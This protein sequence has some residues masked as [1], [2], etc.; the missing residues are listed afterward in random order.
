[1]LLDHRLILFLFFL[2]KTNV[3]PEATLLPKYR[4]TTPQADMG[5]QK[6]VTHE[7]LLSFYKIGGIEAMI[8]APTVE[9]RPCHVLAPPADI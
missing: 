7:Y 8:D 3:S 9:A 2:G 1:M 6:V 4:H 5:K